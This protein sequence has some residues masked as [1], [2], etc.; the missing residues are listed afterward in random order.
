VAGQ[1]AFLVERSSLSEFEETAERLAEEVHERLRLRLLGP[2]P[3][4]SFVSF[5]LEPAGAR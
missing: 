3:P 1:F 4:Y 2:L 5:E